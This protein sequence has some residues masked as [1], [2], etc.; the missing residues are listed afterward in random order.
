MSEHIHFG[1][2]GLTGPDGHDACP[3]GHQHR[4]NWGGRRWLSI[5]G[6]VSPE[7]R[8]SC[9]CGWEAGDGNTTPALE[10]RHDYVHRHCRPS[11]PK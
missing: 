3:C 7:P 4:F 1:A 8:E 9:R 5:R 11:A 10:A 6:G 2:V